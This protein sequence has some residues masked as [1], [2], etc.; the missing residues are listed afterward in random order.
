MSLAGKLNRYT[1]T[2]CRGSVITV[3]RDEGT[4]PFAMGCRAKDGCDGMMSSAFYRGVTGTPTFEWRKATKEEY[5]AAS[6]ELKMH[7][8]MGGLDIHPIQ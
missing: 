3:D 7:F 6:D 8:A 2:T 1:C 5:A 4:T